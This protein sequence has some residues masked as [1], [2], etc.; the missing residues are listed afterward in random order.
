MSH[1]ALTR[2]SDSWATPSARASCAKMKG[3]AA[4]FREASPLK[5]TRVGATSGSP[6]P[7]GPRN[8]TG[9]TP[10]S[11]Q[12]GLV[13]VTWKSCKAMEMS[14][15]ILAHEEPVISAGLSQRCVYVTCESGEG[16]IELHVASIIRESTPA[17]CVTASHP[18]F[19]GRTSHYLLSS[20]GRSQA[21]GPAALELIRTRHLYNG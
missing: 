19:P 13:E 11:R 14:F 4:P 9:S 18:W 8:A 10:T 12:V 6:V 17:R 20:R 5:A 16:A 15:R 7:S 2:P 3:S 21:G 1:L